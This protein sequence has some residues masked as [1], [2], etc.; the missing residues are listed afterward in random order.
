MHNVSDTLFYDIN[1]YS[2][3]IRAY[4]HYNTNQRA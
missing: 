1:W 4:S 3:Y 2:E